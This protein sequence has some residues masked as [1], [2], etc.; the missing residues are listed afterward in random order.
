M[1][2]VERLREKRV[3]MGFRRRNARETER[4]RDKG[5]EGAHRSAYLPWR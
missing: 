4:E 5:H 1:G 3:N 2:A